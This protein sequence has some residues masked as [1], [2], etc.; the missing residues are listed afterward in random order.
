[1]CVSACIDL[2]HA[3]QTS[4]GCEE[5]E[6]KEGGPGGSIHIIKQCEVC[7]GGVMAVKKRYIELL[8]AIGL[9]SAD[10]YGLKDFHSSLKI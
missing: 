9:V 6:A 8:I 4:P 2:S 7:F 10:H 1:M 5:E 3:I